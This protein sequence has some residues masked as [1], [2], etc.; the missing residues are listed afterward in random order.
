MG[1][2]GVATRALFDERGMQHAPI[3]E[4]ARAVGIARGLVYLQFSSKEELFV[5]TVTDYL[6]ELGDQLEALASIES[7]PRER[8]TRGMEAY[9]EFLSP[10]PGLSRLRPVAHAPAGYGAPQDG[11]GE[12]MAAPGSR[13]EPLRRLPDRRAGRKKTASTTPSTSR[14]CSGRRY[15]ER[16]TW[17]ASAWGSASLGPGIPE[18]FSV[19]PE[20]VVQ[21]CVD[22]ALGTSRGFAPSEPRLVAGGPVLE[23]LRVAGD[24]S[25]S[26]VIAA[27]ATISGVTSTGSRAALTASSRTTAAAWSRRPDSWAARSRRSSRSSSGRPWR[28]AS[29]IAAPPSGDS[30][31]PS[32]TASSALGARSL[33]AT[34]RTMN[35]PN[36]SE[37]S[38]SSTRTI[39]ALSSVA[40]GLSLSLIG[41]SQM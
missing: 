7:D 41:R 35:C 18:L 8:L 29:A 12:R 17:R 34:C 33:R 25:P 23:A 15:S 14:T 37:A 20:R 21:T 5:L 13:D 1:A 31:M 38:D 22:S 16:C 30:S 9:A 10:L 3:E 36:A 39:S 19:A 4:I 6:D 2:R 28:W 11:V 27:T 24:Q 40:P 26:S 32:I